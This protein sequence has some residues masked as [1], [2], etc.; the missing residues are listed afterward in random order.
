MIFFLNHNIKDSTEQKEI[1]LQAPGDHKLRTSLSVEACP[2]AT[3]KVTGW[4]MPSPLR[5]LPLRKRK[6]PQKYHAKCFSALH[7]CYRVWQSVLPLFYLPCFAKLLFT[8]SLC[9]YL[10]CHARR[11]GKANQSNNIFFFLQCHPQQCYAL[12]FLFRVEVTPS[13]SFKVD[14]SRAQM[15]AFSHARYKFRNKY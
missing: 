7:V 9:K 12:W 2:C 10:L 3:Q 8:L 13:G 6:A 5:W 11:L 15:S 14:Y 4:K 1:P